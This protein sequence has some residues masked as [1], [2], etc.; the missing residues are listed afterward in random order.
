MLKRIATRLAILVVGLIASVALVFATAAPASAQPAPEQGRSSY[1]QHKPKKHHKCG[2]NKGYWH[3]GHW[4]KGKWHKGHWHKAHYHKC[5]KYKQPKH[6]QYSNARY[7]GGVWDRLARCESGGNW[8]INTGNGY[9]GG[10]Q[11][12]LSTWRAYG[13]R[14]YP[15]LASKSEQI[16]VATRVQRGQGWKAWPAC[17]RK[18]GLR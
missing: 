15:H 9:Y 12:S 3:K 17:S 7:G 4:Y 14:G 18:L 16:R 2:W 13:G 8:R 11:H 6:R 5:K 10:L 1:S